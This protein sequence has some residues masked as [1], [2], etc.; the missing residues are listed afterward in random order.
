MKILLMLITLMAATNIFALEMDEK[1]TLRFLKVSN[2]KKTI[3]INRGSEDGLVVGD[4]A[5]FFITSG[6]IAR[7]LV[8]KVSPSRSI[9]SLYRVVDPAE[10]V[11]G[12]VLNLKIA[13][14]VKITDDPSK[15]LKEEEI[16]T[17]AGAAAG[18]AD[19]GAATPKVNADEQKE[20]EGMGLEDVDVPAKKEPKAKKNVPAANE[21][22]V[23][24][25]LHHYGEDTS[26][27]W[28]AWGTLYVNA[29]TGT[30]EDSTAAQSS[31]ASTSSSVDFSGGL[32]RYFLTSDGFLKNTSVIAFIHKRTLET[33]DDVKISSDW[34]E[35][36]GGVNYH[37]YNSAA[38]TNKLIG[39]GGVTFGA[40]SATVTETVTTN[41]VA[42]ETPV[43]GS[44]TFYSLGMGA[45]YV[46]SNGFGVRAL[47]DYYHSSET[48]DYGNSVT[49]TKTL[50]GPRVLF[51]LSYRF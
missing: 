1:L 27:N 37:F 3:L 17:D 40:G 2:S 38:A 18:E 11:D 16:P 25:D 33:G 29:L 28:E 26:K 41:G 43:E 49:V 47:F 30:V 45:K 9:W 14:P 6:V 44:N 4:H 42:T 7:G 10:V 21:V 32:E 36:G 50:S 51:G 23:S 22:S 39:Y 8:E 24:E 20:L 19:A 31:T 46:L 35:Y 5:K 34:F 12:K 48:Y 15:S 13:S